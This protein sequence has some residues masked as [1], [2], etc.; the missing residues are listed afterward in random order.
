MHV[1]G[2]LLVATDAGCFFS[3]LA[4]STRGHSLLAPESDF[5]VVVLSNPAEIVVENQTFCNKR[6]LP[7]FKTVIVLILIDDG[8]PSL[9]H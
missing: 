8:K 7:P 3:G 1:T 9:Y 2:V 4:S 5:M 6:S